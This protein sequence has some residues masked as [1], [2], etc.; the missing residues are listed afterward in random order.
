MVTTQIELPDIVY[1]RATRAAKS[2]G[3]SLADFARAE[4]ERAVA[5][6]VPV[7]AKPPKRKWRLPGPF[8]LDIRPGM[9][10]GKLKEIAQRDPYEERLSESLKG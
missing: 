10:D 1:R 7:Q 2:R 5:L 3:V 9:T 6:A 8:G 4:I